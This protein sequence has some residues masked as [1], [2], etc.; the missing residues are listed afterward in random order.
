[1]YFFLDHVYKPDWFVKLK[2]EK[3]K[4]YLAV[5]FM[6]VVYHW[7]LIITTTF[8]YT[9]LCDSPFSYIRLDMTCLRTYRPFYSHMVTL[10]LAY[11]T[12]DFILSLIAY[13]DFSLR[14]L[15]FIF[16]HLCT[17]ASYVFGIYGGYS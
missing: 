10:Q 3:D 13:A 16:H 6:S 17:G 14:G 2:D 7:T 15:Q 1:M 11:V 9:Q 8:T 4:E 5:M 12:H